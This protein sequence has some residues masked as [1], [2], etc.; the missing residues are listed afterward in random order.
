MA[1]STAVL[2]VR[3]A[4][5]QGARAAEIAARL[6]LPRAPTPAA[7][8]VRVEPDGLTLA[9][10]GPSAQRSGV[11]ADLARV[12]PGQERVVRAVRG[13]RRTE[14]VG[15]VVDATAGLGGDAGALIRAGFEVVMIERHPVLG[16]LLEDAVTRFVREGRPARGGG[17][18]PVPTLHVGNALEILGTLVPR[19]EVVYL[20]PMHPRLG[21][22]A[23]RGGMALLR[24][25][26]T[27]PDA[28][29]QRALLTAA[30]A[31]AGRRV[32]LKRPAKAPPLAPDP[33]GSI[34]GRTVRFDLYAPER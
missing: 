9:P 10:C 28:S 34:V 15:R 1:T 32:V 22:G 14:R 24:E 3:A 2:R 29:E 6:G 4:P 12:R 7:Y 30:R 20:D 33:S 17:Q 23:K 8:E 5:G 13:R 18:A 19:P 26:L 31:A 21:G 11:R 16:V 27:A 25:M